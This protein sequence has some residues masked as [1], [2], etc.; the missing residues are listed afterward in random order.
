MFF[1]CWFVLKIFFWDVSVIIYSGKIGFLI[2]DFFS[3]FVDFSVLLD[4][5]HLPCIVK[6]RKLNENIQGVIKLIDELK[7]PSYL[8]VKWMKI[9]IIF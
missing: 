4:K 7:L 3:F 6:M 1:R 8:C 2:H 5:K 9:F